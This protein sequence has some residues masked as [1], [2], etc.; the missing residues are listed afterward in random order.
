LTEIITAKAIKIKNEKI[1][2]KLGSFYTIGQ[3]WQI[4]AAKSPA[5]LTNLPQFRLRQKATRGVIRKS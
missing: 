3:N 5:S 2:L 4:L 1:K